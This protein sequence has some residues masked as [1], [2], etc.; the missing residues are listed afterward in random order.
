MININ[1]FMKTKKIKIEIEICLQCSTERRKANN[2]KRYL[3]NVF[4]EY[5]SDCI[6]WVEKNKLE[7]NN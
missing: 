6:K 2:G 5:C 7:F 4:S 3:H 1:L